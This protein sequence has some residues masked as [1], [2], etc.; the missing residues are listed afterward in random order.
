MSDPG[1]D[2]I[3][4][5]SAALNA[6]YATES[7]AAP[8]EVLVGG[9]EAGV[10]SGYPAVRWIMGKIRHDAPE[11]A[12]SAFRERQEYAI[13]I[14]AVD[15]EQARGMKN[16]MVRFA[17]AQVGG[18]NLDP[19]T[20]DWVRKSALDA[21]EKLIGTIAVYTD[22]TRDVTTTLATILTQQHTESLDP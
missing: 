1:L 22:I 4:A 10:F 18:A 12:K 13:G 15:A 19:G 8:I 2:F 14:Y 3:A 9:E 5:V 17:R 7:N 16:N 20:W 11:N 21:G 6:H